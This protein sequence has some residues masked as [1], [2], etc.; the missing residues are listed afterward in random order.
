MSYEFLNDVRV[1]DE[2]QEEM[3][4]EPINEKIE[5]AVT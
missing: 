5:T 4:D 1:N 2:F 3:E